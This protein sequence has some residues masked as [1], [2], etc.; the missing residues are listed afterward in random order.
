LT[1]PSLL[2]RGNLAME[3]VNFG[4]K[5]PSVK[6]YNLLLED[7]DGTM[8]KATQILGSPTPVAQVRWA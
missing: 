3:A 4:L 8:S 6:F 5:I 2:S 1:A 7:V